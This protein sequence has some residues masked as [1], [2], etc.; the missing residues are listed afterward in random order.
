MQTDRPNVTNTPTTIDAGHLQIET[1]IA[2]DSLFNHHVDGSSV[3]Q[4]SVSFGQVDLRLGV[5][6]QLELNLAFD[7]YDNDRTRDSAAGIVERDAGYGDTTFGGKLNLWGDEITDDT[8]ATA[9]A[10]QPQLKFPTARNGVGDGRFELSVTVPFLMN[11]PAG[12]HL[13]IQPGLSYERNSGNTGYVTGSENA[14]SIDRETIKILD[15]YLEYADDVTTEKHSKSPQ[16]IDV[17]GI[18]QLTSNV[19]LDGGVNFGLNKITD[20][21]E[22]T[23]GVSVRF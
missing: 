7:S 22:A 10:I 12:F 11:L 23:A 8:W 14:I 1:G 9:L 17:G 15:V 19:S 5:L 20:N 2:D 3:R 4:D 6:N 13:A 18:Y 21:I 16:T